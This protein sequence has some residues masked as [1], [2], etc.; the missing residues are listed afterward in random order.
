M[1]TNLNMSKILKIKKFLYLF[2]KFIV[3]YMKNGCQ[4]KEPEK[5]KI[6]LKAF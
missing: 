5:E 1:K 2:Y 3:L 6:C 4:L